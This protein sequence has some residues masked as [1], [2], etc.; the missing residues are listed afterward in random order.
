MN[1]VSDV[2]VSMGLMHYSH[3]D[4]AAASLPALKDNERS[5]RKVVLNELFEGTTK[6]RLS[7]E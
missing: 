4:K 5:E 1:E 7:K 3:Y 6:P 2:F